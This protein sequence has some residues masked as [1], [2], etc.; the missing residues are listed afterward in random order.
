MCCFC[1]SA[2]LVALAV[3]AAGVVA[4]GSKFVALIIAAAVDVVVLVAVA[5]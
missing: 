4:N 3:V 2:V 1:F 5:L